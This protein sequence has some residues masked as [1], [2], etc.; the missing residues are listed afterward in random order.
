[1]VWAQDDSIPISVTLVGGGVA[2]VYAVK[3]TETVHFNEITEAQVGQLIRIYAWYQNLGAIDD[4][5]IEW[6]DADT[7]EVY[8]TRQANLDT[9]LTDAG[10]IEINM[11]DRDLNINVVGYHLE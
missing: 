10:W 3:V 9:N 11:P 1:M 7:G 8:G 6:I 2:Y 5:K 4:I